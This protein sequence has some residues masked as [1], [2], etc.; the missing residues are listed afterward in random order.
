L[1]QPEAAAMHFNNKVPQQV[2]T[3]AP[4]PSRA[5]YGLS[6]FLGCRASFALFLVWAIVPDSWLKVIGFD[7]L[8]SKYWV[9]ALPVLACVILASTAFLLYPG[10][11]I[12]MTPSPREITA[13]TDDANVPKTKSQNRS[14]P[15]QYFVPSSQV[16]RILYQQQS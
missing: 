8:P 5:I 3:P 14:F 7:F 9:I 1:D 11:G 4:T 15:S 16:S 10:L 12:I 6:L 13:F 2:H